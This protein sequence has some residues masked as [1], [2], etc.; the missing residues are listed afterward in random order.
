MLLNDTEIHSRLE[1]LFPDHGKILF[2]EGRVQPASVDLCVKGSLMRVHAPSFGK[3]PIRPGSSEMME[4]MRSPASLTTPNEPARWVLRSGE[5]YLLSTRE[6]IV[7]PNDLLARLDGR[8]SW[9][10]VGLRVHA[11]AGFLDPG[12]VGH[13]TLEL[14]V[15]GPS[16]E[17]REGDSI[18]QVSFQ[19]LVGPAERPYG[20]KGSKYQNQT[21]V[22]ASRT[23]DKLP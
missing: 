8:S 3:D 17:L 20:S 16:V 23:V 7:V 22:T 15:V 9:A 6:R 11:T 18:C 2:D 19:K 12:F 10:R 13:I 21:G 4:V 1:S 5:L 14:D